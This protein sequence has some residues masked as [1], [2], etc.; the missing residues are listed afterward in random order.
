[1]GLE[2]D[3]NK[4]SYFIGGS[5]RLHITIHNGVKVQEVYK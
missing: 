3:N 5:N 1:M 2:L 4:T